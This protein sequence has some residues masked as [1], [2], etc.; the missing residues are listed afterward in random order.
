V[1]RAWKFWGKGEYHYT[2]PVTGVLTLY[3]SLRLICEETL[4]RRFERHAESSRQLQQGLLQLGLSLYAPEVCRLPSVIAV[5]MPDGIE[6]KQLITHMIETHRVEV[7]GAF[8][9]P[10]FRIGQMGEQAREHNV[11]R[12]LQALEQSLKALSR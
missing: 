3:E 6:G 7:S 4:E 5:R 8:G 10:I 1:R 9:L 2:A 12:T 11:R